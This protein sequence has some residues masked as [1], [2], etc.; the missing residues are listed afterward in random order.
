MRILVLIG[1]GL[2]LA[3]YT[4]SSREAYHHYLIGQA[5]QP[6]ERIGTGDPGPR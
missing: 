6:K 2:L 1:V 5:V 4:S 3:W